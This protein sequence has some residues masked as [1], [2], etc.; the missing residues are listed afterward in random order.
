[1][2]RAACLCVLVLAFACSSEGQKKPS[3]RDA[4]ASCVDE[5][6]AKLRKCKADCS[7]E[8]CLSDCNVD[9]RSCKARCRGDDDN[10]SRD[11]ATSDAGEQQTRPDASNNG[12]PPTA[13]DGSSQ[14]GGGG[15]GGESGV[16]GSSGEGGAG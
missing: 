15:F 7:G 6:N 11:A 14:E 4:V 13:A 3:A 8:L 9:D 1:M 2:I 16:G 12:S 5:C 10:E